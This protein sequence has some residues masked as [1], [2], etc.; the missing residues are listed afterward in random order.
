MTTH[1]RSPLAS[2]QW[3]KQG[4][5]LGRHNPRAVIGGAALLGLV[6]LLP[7]LLQ[8]LLQNLLQP[9][10]GGLAVIMGLSALLSVVLMPP[11]IG[12]Y[13]RL[14]D[15]AE[16]GRPTQPLDVFEPFKSGAD[17]GRLIG[18]G[19]LMTLVYLV[20][21]FIAISLFGD[22]FIEWYVQILQLSQQAQQG[23]QIDPASVPPL[24]DAFGAL[25]ALGAVI[26]L[27]LGGVYAIGFGQVALGGQGAGRAFADGVAGTLKNLLPL[28]LLALMAFAL[29]LGMSFALILVAGALA[30]LGGA[31]HPV[32]AA[33]LVAPLYLVYLLVLYVVMFGVMYHLWRDVAAA[34]PSAM[35]PGSVE[36]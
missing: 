12:G 35:P 29:L 22:G 31:V 18:F 6:S 5:N 23:A 32:L 3:L 34:A 28:A 25:L 2:L 30:L 24:P 27:F 4:I 26:G 20:L 1:A 7:G 13:L 11:I 9:G 33:V 14:I 19:V 21:G 36:L 17:A 15:A 10:E 8:V 16:H